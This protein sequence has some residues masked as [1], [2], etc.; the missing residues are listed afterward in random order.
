[1]IRAFQHPA[2]IGTLRPFRAALVL[3]MLQET[4][5]EN[6]RIHMPRRVQP[7]PVRRHMV[8][9]IEAQAAEH[10]GGNFAAFLRHVG[11]QRVQG[12]EFRR[13][14][15]EAAQ[16]AIDPRHPVIGHA[17]TGLAFGIGGFGIGIDGLVHQ[18]P[19]IGRVLQHQPMQE[20]GAGA[21]QPGD[22][23]RSRHR[24][25]QYR[26]RL[27]LLR[28]QAQQIGQEAPDIPLRRDPPDHAQL[29]LG[30]AGGEEA[31]QRVDE[32]HVTEIAV[33]RPAAGRGN[34]RVRGQGTIQKTQPIRYAI[35]GAEQ[36][37][38]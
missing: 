35:Q 17:R 31:P 14:P 16:L 38:S 13:Q 22:E 7:F 21:W 23:D 20:G 24:L 6:I 12:A 33:A 19:A 3:Q 29:R 1:M 11:F 5:V 15:F 34:E 37:S 26:R 8:V 28:P 30:I 4:L 9:R 2:R 10:V 18:R 32:R 27:R 25:V 36:A